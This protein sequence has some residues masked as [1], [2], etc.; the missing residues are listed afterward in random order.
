MPEGL[1]K[2]L[3][4]LKQLS[5]ATSQDLF[6]SDAL[7]RL[8]PLVRQ[9]ELLAARYDAVV[10]NPPYMG[11]RDESPVKRFAKDYFPDAK[12]NLFACFI[13][14]GITLQASVTTRWSLCRAG[15][16]SPSFEKI[17]EGLCEEK[18]IQTMAHFGARAFGSISGE[19]VQTTAFVLRTSRSLSTDRRSFGCWTVPR[20]EAAALGREIRFDS[21]AQRNS[22]RSR[23]PHRL[24]GERTFSGP[25]TREASRR[26]C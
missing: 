1:A 16:S 5:E 11:G 19:V 4:A 24:L 15:C 13:E 20:R 23:E 14:R 6:V 18:T 26:I 21:I 22:R 25:F 10:A 17:A 12:S 2:K 3:P 8:G 9:A 7:E